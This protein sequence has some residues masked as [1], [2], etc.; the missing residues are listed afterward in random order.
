MDRCYWNR[1]GRDYDGE[2]FD[3]FNEDTKGIV[4]DTVERYGCRRHAASDIGCGIGKCLP[5]LAARFR[6]VLAVDYS[7]T[8]IAGARAVCREHGLANVS[9]R[10][11]DLAGPRARLPRVDF[12]LSV[13]SLIASS[14]TV[15]HRMLKAVAR[16]LKAGG[17]LVLVVPSTESV[18]LTHARRIEWNLRSG[19]RTSSADRAGFGPQ[20]DADNRRLYQGILRIDGVG[21][22]HY[23]REELAVVLAGAGLRVKE[24]LKVEYSWKTEFPQPPRWMKA[25]YPW[26]WLCVAERVR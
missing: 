14:L 23:T 7:H 15:R 19:T 24:T 1:M 26:D 20:A 2:I 16:H 9:L 10:T 6:T 11:M 17:H 12:A 22:K 3:V 4:L 21:T 18:M 13:N 8:C 25:P 5:F